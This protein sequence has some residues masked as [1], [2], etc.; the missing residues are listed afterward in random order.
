MT[1]ALV[2][3]ALTYLTASLNTVSYLFRH[4]TSAST[5]RSYSTAEKR[6]FTVTDKI[7]TDPRMQTVPDEWHHRTDERRTTTITW[8]IVIFVA[9]ALQQQKPLAPRT[10][11]TYLSGV[12][13]Y[14]KNEGVDTRFM[15]KSH[16]IRNT[17]QGLAQY[18]RAYTNQTD[19]DRE[20]MPVT[21]DMI[22]H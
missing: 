4:S 6:W 11:S 9:S 1:R 2:A 7:G 5:A 15:N 21:A 14:L 22:R 13:K 19:G 17:K 3:G 16:D 18:Y 12:R 10:I 20:R 8:C